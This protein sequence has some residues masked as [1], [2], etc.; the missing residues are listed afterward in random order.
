MLFTV[1]L[2]FVNDK[3]VDYNVG[4][5]RDIINVQ[6]NLK[7]ILNFFLHQKL[8]KAIYVFIIGP[9]S[10]ITSM[11]VSNQQQTV[12][13]DKLVDLDLPQK[14][15]VPN[16]PDFILDALPYETCEKIYETFDTDTSVMNWRNLAAWLGL[17]VKDVRRIERLGSNFTRNVIQTWETQT[18][19]D[20]D[21]FIGILRKESITKLADEIQAA[22]SG[23]AT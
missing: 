18:G 1:P 4:T 23:Q 15:H 13:N 22:R 12:V 5:P 6:G 17:K 20:I 2:V 3:N 9:P 7:Y 21:K 16:S 14:P 19:N 11:K 8:E 10:A